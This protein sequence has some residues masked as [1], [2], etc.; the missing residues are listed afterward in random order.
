[1]FITGKHIRRRAFLRGAGVT[2]ALPFLESMIPALARADAVS[3]P[4]T[5]LVVLFSPHGWA[6]TYWADNRKEGLEGVNIVN[7]EERNAGLGF[8]HQPLAPWRDTVTIVAGLD[9]TSSMPPPGTTGGDHDRAAAVFSGLPPKKTTGADIQCGT[10]IDQIVA[11]TYGQE[12]LLPSMQLAIEDP[13]ANTGV[14]GYGYS[15]AY[16]NSIS[17]AG[18]SKPLPHEIN[19]MAV[20]RSMYGDGSTLEERKARRDADASILDKITRK[21]GRFERNLPAEDRTRLNDYLDA[22][23]ELERRLQIAQKLSAESPSMDV[24]FGVPE[25]FDEHIKLLFDLQAL[26]LQGDITRVTSLMIARD[27][28]LRSYPE[29]GVKTGNH[30]ASHH[31]E[32]PQRLE[33]YAKINQYH[34]KCIAYFLKKLQAIPDGEGTLYDHSL[35][36]WGSNMGNSNQHN[37]T[38]VGYLLAGGASG[39]HKARLNVTAQGPTANLLLTILHIMGIEKDS[40]GDSTR[41]VSI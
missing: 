1:M 20:F 8:I 36:V 21:I 12:T 13:A 18:P 28:S 30:A 35:I 32:N 40:I 15:C 23:R 17:W 26:A 5:R 34:C 4:K 19:P 25:S 24:P 14:C 6:P 37:H 22:V 9:A 11:Q 31:G 2:V 27:I 16:S 10:S 3:R 7:P 41:P 33:E 39:Q 29:S 38:D